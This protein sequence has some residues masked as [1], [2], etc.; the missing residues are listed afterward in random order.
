MQL[1][2]Y[3]IRHTRGGLGTADN[4]RRRSPSE[5]VAQNTNGRLIPAAC[6]VDRETLVPG[7]RRIRRPIARAA[8][9]A[10]AGDYGVVTERPDGATVWRVVEYVRFGEN[11][12]SRCRVLRVVTVP[13]TGLSRR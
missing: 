7:G 9:A 5:D 6:R 12:V 3:L 10:S 1:R 11:T 8:S 13:V 2:R 4:Q